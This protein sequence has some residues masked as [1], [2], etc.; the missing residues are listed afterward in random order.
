MKN[1]TKEMFLHT[2]STLF[3][4]KGYHAT[5]INEILKKSQAPKG[6]L[7]YYFPHGKEQLAI[8]S[9]EL[10]AQKIYAEIKTTLAQYD[11]PI[12]GLQQHLQQLA[13]KIQE[14]IDNPR[15]DKDNIS[16]SL[17]ALETFFS[18]DPIRNRCKE[19]FSQMQSIY[20]DNFIKY[21]YNT[22]TANIL[23][24]NA[25]IMT[26]GAII[27]SVTQKNSLPLRQLADN[28]PLL[29]NLD[30]KSR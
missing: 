19:I 9:L 18:N 1:N 6:S 24:M 2:A 12:Q 26:E 15:E 30:V 14:D 20:A 29:F 23:A 25:V 27:L 21:G 5:G 16:I 28:L 7:Y 3:A 10:T 8:E 17:I 22:E 13:Q 4:I 11:D